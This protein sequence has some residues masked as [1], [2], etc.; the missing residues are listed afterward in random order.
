[1]KK[2][3]LILLF[4]CLAIQS[5]VSQEV[6]WIHPGSKNDLE[7][8]TLIFKFEPHIISETSNAEIY[9]VDRM[10]PTIKKN[11]DLS[12]TTTGDTFKLDKN[13]TDTVKSDLLYKTIET[14]TIIAG[15][16]S[17]TL[18]ENLN[19]SANTKLLSQ[20]TAT[21][22]INTIYESILQ[23]EDT[24]VI[25]HLPTTSRD[26]IVLETTAHS[27]DSTI[28]KRTRFINNDDVGTLI[29]SKTNSETV[30]L[31]IKNNVFGSAT[32]L[33]TAV[34]TTFIE[35]PHSVS[36]IS[37]G[38]SDKSTIK[39]SESAFSSNNFD[40]KN[41]VTIVNKPFQ[42]KIT[43]PS[44]P[45][46]LKTI[47]SQIVSYN[48]ADAVT[49]NYQHSLQTSS[50]TNVYTFAGTSLLNEVKSYKSV[51]GKNTRSTKLNYDQISMKMK[52]SIVLKPT[53]TMPFM[54]SPKLTLL[55]M[56]DFSTS[57]MLVSQFTYLPTATG[58]T[59][60][61]LF[62]N[63]ESI[64]K[65]IDLQTDKLTSEIVSH[66]VLHHSH[67]FTN[68]QTETEYLSTISG[69][70][71][72]E[73][74]SST[75]LNTE[76]TFKNPIETL[77]SS[78]TPVIGYYSLPESVLLFSTPEQVK[79]VS[80]EIEDKT[81]TLVE[82]QS[83]N[84]TPKEAA[85]EIFISNDWENNF[86]T[87]EFALPKTT[88]SKYKFHSAATTDLQIFTSNTLEKSYLLSSETVLSSESEIHAVTDSTSLEFDR[89]SSLNFLKYTF[90]TIMR[91]TLI[92]EIDFSDSDYTQIES[93]TGAFMHIKETSFPFIPIS[94]GIAT[95]DVNKLSSA[96]V[97]P[98]S[99]V[100]YTAF[101][102][103]VLIS[104]TASPI[105]PISTG[106]E[107]INVINFSA[108]DEWFSYLSLHTNF[109]ERIFSTKISSE[110]TSF[111]INILSTNINE[112]FSTE[113]R[114]S[115]I[116]PTLTSEEKIEFTKT[117]SEFTPFSINI[118]STNINELSSTEERYSVNYPTLTSEKKIAS[119]ETSSQFNTAS[120]NMA[121]PT[122]EKLSSVNDGH[123]ILY[124]SISS[125]KVFSFTETTSAT[126]P[127]IAD[128]TG[129]KNYLTRK[130][131]S[132]DVLLHF[133]TNEPSKTAHQSHNNHFSS[134]KSHYPATK[135]EN[136]SE[137]L[138]FETPSSKKETKSTRNAVSSFLPHSVTQT[139]INS[140]T[141]SLSAVKEPTATFIEEQ[142][143]SEF[144]YSR[145]ESAISVATTVLNPI[146]LLSAHPNVI[147]RNMHI[148]ITLFGNGFQFNFFKIYVNEMELE[149][150]NFRIHS[151]NIINFTLEPSNKP[152]YYLQLRSSIS[153]SNKIP[154][155]TFDNARNVTVNP[156]TL[157]VKEATYV[158]ISGLQNFPDSSSSCIFLAEEFA[159]SSKAVYMDN[160]FSCISP[161]VPYSTDL[162]M[163]FQYSRALEEEINEELFAIKI[164]DA[165]SFKVF[166][167]APK[168]TQA[169]FSDTGSSII[170]K[171]DK[172][173]SISANTIS[174][175][176]LSISEYEFLRCSQVFNVTSLSYGLIQNSD[177]S[178]NF[179][180]E[181]RLNDPYSFSLHLNAS[182]TFSTPS[183][184]EPQQYLGLLNNTI[185]AKGALY[186]RTSFGS[187]QV[188]EPLNIPVPVIL[189]N[190]PQKISSCVHYEID[191]SSVY[192]SGGRIWR[193]VS[194]SVVKTNIESMELS[195]LEAF[196][197]S[198]S[199]KVKLGLSKLSL[200]PDTLKI[201]AY[202]FVVSF[203]NFLSG[204]ATKEF[205][206]TRFNTTD[207][208]LIVLS[209]D[210][211]YIKVPNSRYN[212]LRADAIPSCEILKQIFYKWTQIEGP[213]IN[214]SA[215]A[216][217][218]PILALKPFSMQPLTT[219]SF[220]VSVNY[221]GSSTYD[222]EITIKT[223]IDKIDVNPGPSKIIGLKNNFMLQPQVGSDGYS[224]ID[225]SIF[226]CHWE[227]SINQRACTSK[228]TNE[229]LT[230]D[231]SCSFLNIT[232]QLDVGDYA[233][234][235][236]VTNTIT[237]STAVGICFI[238]LINGFIPQVNLFASSIKPGRGSSF[239]IE[240]K[241]ELNTISGNPTYLWTSESQCNGI[242]YSKIPL[243]NFETTLTEPSN[244]VLKIK[245]N[246]LLQK[247][248]CFALTVFDTVKNAWG[249]S[250]ITI[251]IRE[252]PSGGLCSLSDGPTIGFEYRTEFLFKC[253]GF[254]TD[255]ESYPLNYNFF[256]KTFNDTLLNSWIPIQSSSKALL[257]TVLPSGNF[258]LKVVVS[259]STNSQ[260]DGSIIEPVVVKKNNYT[261]NF[262]RRQLSTD[263]ESRN[264]LASVNAEFTSTYN[265]NKA[266]T[267][268]SI[269]LAAQIAA[270]LIFELIGHGRN[271]DGSISEVLFNILKTVIESINITPS[272]CYDTST[273]T[274][275]INTI[276][277][278][279]TSIVV[280]NI[281]SIPISN[282][283]TKTLTK[284]NECQMRTMACGENTF[285][286]HGQ[287]VN[288]TL[289]KLNNAQNEFDQ[290][291]CNFKADK[292]DDNI[293]CIKYQCKNLKINK[294]LETKFNEQSIRNLSLVSNA[295]LSVRF[296]DSATDL[297]IFPKHS[298]LGS[299]N[300]LESE[301]KSFEDLEIIN[302]NSDNDLSKFYLEHKNVEYLTVKNNSVQFLAKLAGS[303]F[304]VNKLTLSPNSPVTQTIVLSSS[305]AISPTETAIT[306]TES[307][308]LGLIGGVVGSV[309]T[310]FIAVLGI[311]LIKRSR[312]KKL[313]KLIALKELDSINENVV[314]NE[315]IEILD[316]PQINQKSQDQVKLDNIENSFNLMEIQN[317]MDEANNSNDL[318]N[319]FS[320]EN[321]LP[322]DNLDSA[323]GSSEQVASRGL[324][325]AAKSLNLPVQNPRLPLYLPVMPYWIHTA[326]PEPVHQESNINQVD[327]SPEALEKTQEVKSNNFHLREYENGKE[328]ILTPTPPTSKKEVATTSLS[329]AQMVEQK[330]REKK[331]QINLTSP[332][333]QKSPIGISRDIQNNKQN[334]EN[335]TDKIVQLKDT[336]IYNPV[337]TLSETKVTTGPS[338]EL[339]ESVQENPSDQSHSKVLDKRGSEPNVASGASNAV[340]IDRK[341]NNITSVIENFQPSNVDSSTYKNS[342]KPS[343]VRVNSNA[344]SIKNELTEDVHFDG[345]FFHISTLD[346]EIEALR[347]KIAKKNSIKKKK[348]SLI[349][350][351]NACKVEEKN[352]LDTSKYSASRSTNETETET[353]DS[354]SKDALKE[355][356]DEKKETEKYLPVPKRET[357]APELSHNVNNMNK[358][359][360]A[361]AN[362]NNFDLKRYEEELVDRKRKKLEKYKNFSEVSISGLERSNSDILSSHEDFDS[363]KIREERIRALKTVNCEEKPKL[364]NIY[365]KGKSDT[366][367]VEDVD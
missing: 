92:T 4:H 218:L 161:A 114:F 137:D 186:S 209:S 222:F 187:F 33:E 299:F 205:S 197:S 254:T 143:S 145:T 358:D 352:S 91:E 225:I 72:V 217:S 85:T 292:F 47:S 233:F 45:Y 129:T 158:K 190:A 189:I 149:N 226:S 301:A 303:F 131:S 200:S 309:L 234:S 289:G 88:E 154:I 351:S 274:N 239:F 335:T 256:M 324:Q 344:K 46:K 12:L 340:T 231:K 300:L 60:S 183:V 122:I 95:L 243:I 100:P 70:Q 128:H 146:N 244:A 364:N 198:E 110:F 23:I 26:G 184:I 331:K 133:S 252:S 48:E 73:M 29:P 346:S 207:V 80:S 2:K 83:L 79:V 105:E 359:E 3:K 201:G 192:G 311:F 220:K 56:N 297:E 42:T 333:V 90:D 321:L 212:I 157:N 115:T 319:S 215:E 275:F 147:P 44:S 302:F 7:S 123:S 107:T 277:S 51:V 177:S 30:L 214:I 330:Y 172:E 249:R 296:H 204:T 16:E 293:S 71:L 360:E 314:V 141:W 18:K 276:D 5:L 320:N 14:S 86:S 25:L 153:N 219:Y 270:S 188:K 50:F 104:E 304:L 185:T 180:C 238:S 134:I 334:V 199:N 174:N 138:N 144:D 257:S 268:L 179:D 193:K 363:S 263:Q 165:P 228:L 69:L 121:T 202:T 112:L 248:Y 265:A 8:S 350:G 102:E 155:Y 1:M 264:Y 227:C 17:A 53:K 135:T 61:T 313:K 246:V 255:L 37:D 63:F 127:V 99:S 109:E 317:V 338:C 260:F 342:K 298:L 130:F 159:W 106:I 284:I 57:N 213:M 318:N 259:D 38:I 6:N 103:G 306:V 10:Q 329:R 341:L 65:N 31:T 322:N 41:T 269:M 357:I 230:F 108:V 279:L 148:N 232:G 349:S 262:S 323:C 258:L 98:S 250:F 126:I 236:K 34:K 354:D 82:R 140:E 356:I 59:Y 345:L 81:I 164:D 76:V 75:I 175:G 36:G 163:N 271:L 272:G 312:T 348:K 97:Y 150:K 366:V 11:P 316:K 162:Q 242:S 261:K 176:Y 78:F 178:E 52:S 327:F 245:P 332:D 120:T 287:N 365:L 19:A 305:I 290:N 216:S 278:I 208:P 40:I 39:P 118:V 235:I 111:S 196:L 280:N 168:V 281:S 210:N 94:T 182:F 35:N 89:I 194:I 9:H 325:V 253:L 171:F 337:K 353:K 173:F 291:F 224:P 294:I 295:V 166:E 132:S 62:Q 347:Q 68:D 286:F 32:L 142:Y 136:S 24:A 28:S 310:F 336:Q 339:N 55:L 307:N 247:S 117:S 124:P 282:A 125:T 170:V 15:S 288:F 328:N 266:I 27:V 326:S 160:Y 223:A 251:K 343:I 66:T 240:G 361:A 74:A 101:E 152:I 181:L 67:K 229:T 267:G 119:A 93:S 206:V 43:E 315:D 116:Y 49:L 169:I 285:N 191:F 308:N 151:D 195:K 58:N 139:N 13:P 22:D 77:S 21:T 20:S 54:E 96:E 355:K 156:S 211:G 367:K 113:E 203:E 221:D 87:F 64:A 241:P 362:L 283:L 237:N 273:A 84:P 167:E